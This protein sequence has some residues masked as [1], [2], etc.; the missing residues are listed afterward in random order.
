MKFDVAI[1]F[2]KGQKVEDYFS[3]NISTDYSGDA[4]TATWETLSIT[5][6]PEGTNWSFVT[7]EGID[8]SAY[9]G[10]KIHLGFLYKSDSKAAP[11]VEIQDLSI[12]E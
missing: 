7:I 11:T 8:M 6:W 10:Q 4:T 5:G 12:Q 9:V 2:L 1:N 3:V